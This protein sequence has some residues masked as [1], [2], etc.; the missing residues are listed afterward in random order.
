MLLFCCKT[1]QKT[2]KDIIEKA[3]LKETSLHQLALKC[4]IQD[5]TK[6][7]NKFID[8]LKSF[9]GFLHRGNTAPTFQTDSKGSP[10]GGRRWKR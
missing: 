1:L 4:D 3:S 9:I 10:R 5:T 6:F 7:V 8:A 2:N